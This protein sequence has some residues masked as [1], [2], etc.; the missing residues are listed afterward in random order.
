MGYLPFGSS[1]ASACGGPLLCAP[2]SRQV[3]LFLAQSILYYWCR[4]SADG[5]LLFASR[6]YFSCKRVFFLSGR[7]WVRTSVLCRVKADPWCRSCSPVFRNTCK[8]ALLPLLIFALV[9]SCSCG[10]VYR[11]V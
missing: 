9:R 1:A 4:K 8:S 2:A 5:S 6:L 10:L 11:L 7:C 3:R